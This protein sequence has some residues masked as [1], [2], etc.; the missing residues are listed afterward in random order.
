MRERQNVGDF[1]RIAAVRAG[2]PAA[3]A[4]IREGDLLRGINGEPVGDVVDY[5]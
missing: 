1:G 2:S 5:R 4:G 3:E